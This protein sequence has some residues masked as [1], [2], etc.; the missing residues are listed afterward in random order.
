MRT[1]K[2]VITIAIATGVLSTAGFAQKE[3]EKP[4][5]EKTQEI[6]IRKSG[7]KGE[8]MTIVVDGDNIT[9]NGKSIDKL[10][11][12]DVQI[13]K[14]DSRAEGPRVRLI[15]PG[16]NANRRQ[17]QDADAFS[18]AG[19]NRAMLG[20]VTVQAEGGAKITE[21]TKESGA[22]KAGLK[23]DDIITKVGDKKIENSNDLIATIGTHKPNDKV[24]VTYKRNGKEVKTSATLGESKTRSF[25]MNG[26]YEGMD[27][28]DNL[29][30][31]FGSGFTFNRKPKVGLQIMDVE[32]GTGVQ[33]REVEDESAAS[34]A[35]LKE[36][37]VITEVN[38][39]SIAGV[40]AM[41][42]QIKDIKEGDSFKMTYRRGGNTQTAEVKIP[43]RLKTAN[44]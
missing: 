13:Y 39:K 15:A 34:K 7:E 29:I 10:T 24:D 42:E 16:A 28:P 17:L 5:K 33:I 14:R 44:L 9:L 43:K 25:T 32:E 27:Y 36:G 37:D 8:K 20:V 12:A 21:V 3:S 1:W 2:N 31:P 6:I 11:D 35:G 26:N 18:I 41:K 22:E 4:A 38:G 40:D 19:S 23:E 30:A